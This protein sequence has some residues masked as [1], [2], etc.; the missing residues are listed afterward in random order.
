[1]KTIIA[2][3]LALALAGSAASAGDIKGGS[4]LLDDRS[5]AQLERWKG[6]G[7][8]N[9]TNVYTRQPGDTSLDFH[10]AADGKGPTFTL[11]QL[12]NAAGDSYLVGGYNPQSWSSTDGWHVT[13]SDAER[14]A[15]LFNMTEPAVYRQVPSTYI[16]PSQGSRQTLNESEYGPAFGAGHDLFVNDRLDTAFSYQLTYGDP[17]D[18]GRS[19]IDRSVGVQLV[20]VDAMELFTLSPVPEPATAALWAAGLGVLRLAARKRKRKACAA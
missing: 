4:S 19:I 1:M 12:T 17:R 11:L 15:F 8:F 3:G 9:L 16:L 20:E 18:E 2:T 6:A 13:E 10:A 14:T 5:H 7:E